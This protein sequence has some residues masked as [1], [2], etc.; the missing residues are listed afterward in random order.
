M[1]TWQDDEPRAAEVAH[2][3]NTAALRTQL[4]AAEGECE[5]LCALVKRLDDDAH[6]ER[7]RLL[8]AHSREVNHIWQRVTLTEGRAHIW[9]LALMQALQDNEA[10]RD[11]LR[12]CAPLDTP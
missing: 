8:D 3:E 6:A 12:K 1:T 7:Q 4:A 9:Q 11:Q 2:D 5:R 10:L